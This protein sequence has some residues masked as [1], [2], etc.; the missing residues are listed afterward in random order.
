MNY[1]IEKTVLLYKQLPLC[2]K[3]RKIPLGEGHAASL[4]ADPMVGHMQIKT[5]F[6]RVL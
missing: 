3:N 5:M 2:P 4:E 1:I 6:K